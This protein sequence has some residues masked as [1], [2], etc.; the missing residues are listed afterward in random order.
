MKICIFGASSDSI[1]PEYLSSAENFGRMIAEGGHTMLFG[2]GAHGVM[3]AAARGASAAGGSIIGIA[4]SFFDREGVLFGGC[5]EFIFTETM[6]ERKA[7]L[8][9][10]ADAF[11]V[12]PGGIGTYEEFFEV[13]VLCQLGRMSKPIAVYN[14]AGCYNKLRE[15]LES[16]VD[17]GFMQPSCL[18]LCR[19]CTD[20]DEI[21]DY[22][23]KYGV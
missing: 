16:V 23:D 10:G 15:L 21:F 8:E 6:R 3:G 9:D 2:G 19:F 7:A 13:L 20:I 17:G 12:L 11:A 18:S 5:T 1:L 22:F 4:P 14:V